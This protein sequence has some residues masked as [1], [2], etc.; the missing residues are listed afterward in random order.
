MPNAHERASSTE[1]R[2]NLQKVRNKSTLSREYL[3]RAFRLILITSIILH[4]RVILGVGSL[5]RFVS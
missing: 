4:A 5:F 1:R 3:E 2:E